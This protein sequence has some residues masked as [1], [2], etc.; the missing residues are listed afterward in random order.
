M[1]RCL[2]VLFVLVLILGCFA[3]SYA[4]FMDQLGKVL[5]TTE[6]V[7]GDGANHDTVKQ[8]ETQPQESSAQHQSKY[9]NYIELKQGIYNIPFGA[10]INAVASWCDKQNVK[11]EHISKDEIEERIK[12]GVVDNVGGLSEETYF[13]DV[14]R[15]VKELSQFTIP[16]IKDLIKKIKNRE[17]IPYYFISL[18]IKA[19]ED[20]ISFLE[21]PPPSVKYND[22]E[23]YLQETFSCDALRNSEVKDICSYP[24]LSKRNYQLNIIPNQGTELAN[25]GVERIIIKFYKDD[26][27]QLKFYLCIAQ[28]HASSEQKILDL[29]DIMSEKY[30]QYS[31]VRPGGERKDEVDI[32]SVNRVGSLRGDT[33][34][35]FGKNLILFAGTDSF[36]GYNS[37][38][39]RYLSYELL[40]AEPTLMKKVINNYNSTVEL[41]AKDSEKKA[42]DSKQRMKNN[43]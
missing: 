11:L 42:I 15:G 16:Q 22:K 37:F 27:Q 26:D 39:F 5:S 31:M 18:D 24:S 6:Q 30:G 4:G 41:L 33:L 1:Q 3:F 25:D 23:Y 2:F 34:F 10:D 29:L 13:K 17:K 9:S 35:V 43:F 36:D 28:V 40:Y 38:S 21:N 20:D 32:L 19:I 12:R 8:K 7:L 14:E